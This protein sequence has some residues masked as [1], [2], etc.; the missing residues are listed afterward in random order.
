MSFAVFQIYSEHGHR[1]QMGLAFEWEWSPFTPHWERC[2]G[3]SAEINYFSK[4]SRDETIKMKGRCRDT[5]VHPAKRERG[6]GIGPG[7]SLCEA[8]EQTVLPPRGT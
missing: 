3:T 6:G 4:M 1:E 8:A 2:V 7:L 5:N